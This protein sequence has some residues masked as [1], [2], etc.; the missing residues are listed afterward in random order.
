MTTDYLNN[1][2]HSSAHLL[3][4]A[5]LKLY[6]KVSPT[7]GPAIEDKF[8]YDFDFGDIKINEEDL[9]KIEAEIF[10]YINLVNLEIYVE[11]VM[12]KI[13]PKKSNFSNFYQSLEPIGEVMKKIK[14]WL[15]FMEQPSL[16]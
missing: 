8:Y 16:L 11:V 9:P 5:V 13:R 14:C 6:P 10:L 12:L 3:A 4:A 15:E 7:I 2:R 1:L